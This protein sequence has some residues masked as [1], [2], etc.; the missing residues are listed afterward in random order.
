[1]V[2][3]SLLNPQLNGRWF[4][5]NRS[6]TRKFLGGLTKGAFSAV[7]AHVPVDQYPLGVE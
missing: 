6:T 1:M 7:R 2:P 5:T 3:V 4:F